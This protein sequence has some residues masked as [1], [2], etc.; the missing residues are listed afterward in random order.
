MSRVSGE[1]HQQPENRHEPAESQEPCPPGGA[2]IEGLDEV[3]LVEESPAPP[4]P[5]PARPCPTTGTALPPG[6]GSSSADGCSPPRPEDYRAR[7]RPGVARQT[8]PH[9]PMKKTHEHWRPG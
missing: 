3:V 8:R 7:Q 5:V 2:E 6:P 1:E 9:A 4:T